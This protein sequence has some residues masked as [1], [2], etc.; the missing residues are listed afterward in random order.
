MAL[1]A[2]ISTGEA[3]E[4]QRLHKTTYKTF[5][6][7]SD[8]TVTTA[9]FTGKMQSVFGWRRNVERN[10]NPRSLMNLPMQ[11]GGSEMMRL[12]A[13]AATEAGIEVCCP[14]HDAFVM[15]APTNRIEDDVAAMRE[16]MSKAGRA[17]TGGLD[18]R[19]DVKIARGPGRYM[20]KRGKGMWDKVM[21]LLEHLGT[22][23]SQW[24]EPTVSP[25][26]PDLL[27]SDTVGRPSHQ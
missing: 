13:I 10:A 15:S 24:R 23:G 12:A 11:A 19:T 27:T 25:V 7:W 1:K 18:V 4:L 21:A 22:P 14:V 8:D 20:D 5:W 2:G 17:V 3:R 26:T 9:L 6:K 16:I